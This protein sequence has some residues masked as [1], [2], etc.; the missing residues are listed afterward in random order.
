M[1]KGISK[2]LKLLLATCGFLFV[3]FSVVVFAVPFNHKYNTTFWNS[4]ILPGVAIITLIFF[5][6]VAFSSTD[7]NNNK[8]GKNVFL[9][10][11]ILVLVEFVAAMILVICNSNFNLPNYVAPVVLWSLYA[12]G[13]F[14]LVIGTINGKEI[15]KAD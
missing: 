1:E 14:L 15:E 8:F 2:N 10:G 11:G 12:I 6:A 3:L 4:Y 13:L 5:V 9:F 7:Y